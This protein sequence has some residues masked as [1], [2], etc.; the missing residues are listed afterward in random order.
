MLT[1]LHVVWCGT[2]GGDSGN[3]NNTAWRIMAEAGQMVEVGM[4]EK[5]ETKTGAA[6]LFRF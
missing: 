6:T 4:E 5:A 2:V 3:G 1:G